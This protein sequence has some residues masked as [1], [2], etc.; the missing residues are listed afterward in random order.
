VDR[1][2]WGP[3]GLRR[4]AAHGAGPA[5]AQF[6]VAH[7]ITGSPAWVAALVMMALADVLTRLAVIYLRG[8]PPH[9]HPGQCD[10]GPGRRRA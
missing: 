10:T 7:H 2:G 9:R 3:D 8:T 6:S 4:R 1:R 5:I